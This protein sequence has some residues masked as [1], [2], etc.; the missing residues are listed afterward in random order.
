MYVAK[1]PNRGSP[2]AVLLRESYREAGKVKNRT[3][4]NL[5]SWPEAKVDA[6]ARVLKGQ[7]AGRGRWR[8]RSRSPAACRTGTSPRCWARRGQLGLEELIDPVPSR[9]RDLVTAMAVAQVIAPD[10]KLA[11][12]R[13]LREETAASSLGEVLGLGGC[14]E[15]DLYAAMDWLAAR[16]DTIQD[17]LA[18]RHLAGG[19]LVLYDVSS[20][21]FEGRTCPLGAIG[22]PKDG[23]RGRLQI[24]YGL[25]TSKDGVPVAIEVF[26][27][28]T[29]D[30]TTVAGQVGK[31]KDRF[32]LTRVVLVGDRGMLTA[33]RLREDVGPAGLDWITALRAPQ[34]KALV[35]DGALQLSLFD[36]T[37]LAE[38]TSPDF[39]GERLVACKNPFLEAER[40]RKRESLLA[41]HRS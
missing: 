41:G 17:A 10:S 28:N 38:I 13:G 6:L 34:V 30:P 14:D 9:Q 16:Q 33:A 7:A 23:V 37:D 5:S 12:A 3:L 22:H 35:R 18:A 20:A 19:T 8:A 31:V 1:V 36:Q 21:A 24:V 29:G 39:P 32:G 11:I 25:L 26:D 15:D 2:P 27:G 4:A 40:A